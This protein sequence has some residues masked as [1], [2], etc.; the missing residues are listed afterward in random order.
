MDIMVNYEKKEISGLLLMG[1]CSF[2]M[3]IALVTGLDNKTEKGVAL[4]NAEPIT[5]TVESKE[6]RKSESLL[7][8][9]NYYVTVDGEEYL[10]KESLWETIEQGDEITFKEYN[11]VLEVED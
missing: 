8:V 1:I 7:G 2:M 6:A 5:E 9:I 4:A 11:G 3:L 10:I